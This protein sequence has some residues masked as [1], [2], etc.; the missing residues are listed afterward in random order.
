MSRADQNETLVTLSCMKWN[1]ADF[2]LCLFLSTK[3]SNWIS[4]AQTKLI[5][6]FFSIVLLLLHLSQRL[7]QVNLVLDSDKK[8]Y[9]QLISG[10]VNLLFF[11]IWFLNPQNFVEV[12]TMSN[13]RS[14]SVCALGQFFLLRLQFTSHLHERYVWNN[15]LRWVSRLVS[16]LMFVCSSNWSIHLS[17]NNSATIQA[18][19]DFLILLW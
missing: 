5:K 19:S 7:A 18:Q 10:S 8:Y 14:F 13:D 17:E 3:K 1:F 4:P 16:C 6:P 9:D 11:F 15:Q 2:L 12:S